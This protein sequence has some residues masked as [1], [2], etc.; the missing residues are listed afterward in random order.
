AEIAGGLRS[1]ARREGATLYMVTHA[2]LDLLLSRWSGQE[3]LVVGSP[4]AGRTQV[5]TESLIGFFVNT[6]TLR[7]DLTGDPS[8]QELVRRVRETALGA[9]AHQEL[10]FERLVEEVAPERGL[11]H[12]PLF[13]VMFQLQSVDPGQGSGE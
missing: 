5:G 7:I 9:Y 4:I 6:L 2:A 10:P 12:T 1:L 13:Q 8:F 3:D 11:S